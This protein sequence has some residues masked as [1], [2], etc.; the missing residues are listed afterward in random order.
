MSG[1]IEIAV[2]LPVEQWNR[3]LTLLGEAPYRVSVSLI[4][5]IQAN[6]RLETLEAR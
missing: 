6:A 1:P 2:S 3:V 4:A 5:A